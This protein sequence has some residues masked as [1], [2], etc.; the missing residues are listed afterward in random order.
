M[1]PKW[2]EVK[3]KAFAKASA[4]GFFSDVAAAK[5]GTGELRRPLTA[6]ERDKRKKRMQMAKAS[7]RA[8]R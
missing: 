2:D 1:I 6:K 5:G 3:Q 8:N 4:M 7:R